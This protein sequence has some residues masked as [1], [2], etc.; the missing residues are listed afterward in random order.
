MRGLGFPNHFSYCFL[1]KENLGLF[2]RFFILVFHN[3]SGKTVHFN[4]GCR[5]KKYPKV[6]V[7]RE[8]GIDTGEK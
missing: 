3:T 4:A 8:T 2:L 6:L 5:I 7:Q 1:T